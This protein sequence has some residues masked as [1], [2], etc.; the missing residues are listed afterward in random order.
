[1]IFDLGAPVTLAGKE[2]M[3]QYIREY[4][5][6]IGDLKQTECHQ[7]FRFRPSKQNVSKIMSK[8]VSKIVKRLDGKDDVLRIFTYFVDADVPFLYCPFPT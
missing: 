3:N 2:W 6:N 5:L 7:I 4:E 1:M 8:I